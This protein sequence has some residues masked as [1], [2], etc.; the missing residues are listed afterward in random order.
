[1]IDPVSREIRSLLA[2]VPEDPLAA[3]VLADY[4]EEQND[5][6]RWRQ[7][8][9]LRLAYTLTRAVE[10]D[11]RARQEE[12]LRTLLRQGVRAIGPYRSVELGGEL[13]MEFAWVPPGVFLM[14]S[15]EGEEGRERD[16]WPQ[17]EG[18]QHEVTLTRGFW[19]GTTPVTRAQYAGIMGNNPT[20]APYD[21]VD[22]PDRHKPV[23]EVEWVDAIAFLEKLSQRAGAAATECRYRLP[24]E[25]EWEYACRAGTT[26][27]FWCGDSEAELAKVAWYGEN[28]G[29]VQPV[30]KAA[31]A[32][33]LH[34]MLGNVWE[35][36]ADWYD[37]GYY[38]RAP[39]KDPVCN[40]AE[41]DLRVIRGG[42]GWNDATR[43]RSAA[44]DANA[45][46][47]SHNDISFRVVADRT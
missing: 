16:G 22:G 47:C 17:D 11:G 4:L 6:R 36:C 10:C 3:F 46:D 27:R 31:N 8:E 18:P 35:W 20:F 45:P 21:R 1:M 15:P 34:D 29:D 2:A 28:S 9:L 25:A 26:T 7:G 12:R 41:I 37:E 40:N 43:C 30:G 24:T 42:G 38:A 23:Q 5:P 33:G 13:T 39:K 44:R 19:M 14:G 32:L